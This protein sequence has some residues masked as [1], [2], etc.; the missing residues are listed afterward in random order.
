MTFAAG[1][2][3]FEQGSIF[4]SGVF[5]GDGTT[6]TDIALRDLTAP[7]GDGRFLRFDEPD[8]NNAGQVAFVAYHIGTSNPVGNDAGLYF[9]DDNLG[10]L[11]IAREGDAFLGSTIRSLEFN[12]T[13]TPNRREYSGLN[14]AGQVAYKFK[15]AD[16]RVG[17]AIWKIPEPASLSLLILVTT[18]MFTQRQNRR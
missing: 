16:H 10:L 11:Q 17:I 14:N 4:N 13:T 6:L 8:I 5:R 1:F 3:S 12:S 2:E 15:L 9:Y 18:T 7:D